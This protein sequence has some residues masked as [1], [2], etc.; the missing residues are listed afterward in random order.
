MRDYTRRGMFDYMF[1]VNDDLVCDATCT[2]SL[3]CSL[4]DAVVLVGV[5]VAVVVDPLR[6]CCY[7]SRRCRHAS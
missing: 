3:V 4:C 5:V 2:G 1:R 7:W 6:H